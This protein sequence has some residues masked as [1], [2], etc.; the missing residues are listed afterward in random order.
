VQ[1]LVGEGPR[2][3]LFD[4]F[5][6]GTTLGSRLISF[7]FSD[8]F[9]P[10]FVCSSTFHFLFSFIMPLFSSLP[11]LHAE[12][13]SSSD[14]VMQSAGHVRGFE[15]NRCGFEVWALLLLFLF[16][17]SEVSFSIRFF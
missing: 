3:N 5:F 2:N 1:L 6:T 17:L 11:G 14:G 16:L 15:L 8:H 9:I 13:S 4:A 12:V 7:T 10:F